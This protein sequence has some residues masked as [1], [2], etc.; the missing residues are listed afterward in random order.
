MKIGVTSNNGFKVD[1]VKNVYASLGIHAEVTGY[2][3][4]SGVGAQ[5]VNESTMEGARNRITDLKK[6]INGLDR[7]ISIENGIFDEDD[8]WTDI[9][10][11]ML[12][13]PHGEREYIVFSDGVIFPQKYVEIARQIGFGRITV[14]KVMAENGYIKDAKDPHKSISG[15]ERQK[16]I[17]EALYKLVTHVEDI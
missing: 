14:G 4:D 5:P 7:I 15:K 6:R 17:E 1:A 10:V 13:D 11:I 8:G 9:A 12:Q 16:Y 2:S 3:T